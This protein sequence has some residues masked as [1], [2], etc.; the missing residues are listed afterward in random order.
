MCSDACAFVRRLIQKHFEEKTL[1][2]RV[3]FSVHENVAK[4]QERKERNKTK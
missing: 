3:A 4:G 1:E 2:T